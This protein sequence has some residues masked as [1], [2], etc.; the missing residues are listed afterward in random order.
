MTTD[1]KPLVKRYRALLDEMRNG[2]WTVAM[3][4]EAVD[5]CFDWD[6]TPQGANA[7]DLPQVL[8]FGFTHAVA[9]M[10]VDGSLIEVASELLKFKPRRAKR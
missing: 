10:R 5:L 2:R 6:Q 8:F 3:A 7:V 4:R 9:E 1:Y